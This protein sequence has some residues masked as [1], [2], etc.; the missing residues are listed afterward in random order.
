MT[1]IIMQFNNW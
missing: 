1:S